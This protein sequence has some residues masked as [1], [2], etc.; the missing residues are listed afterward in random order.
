[1][2]YL[3]FIILHLSFISCLGQNFQIDWK[4][5]YGTVGYD[6][7]KD[8]IQVS[9][10]YLLLNSF[11]QK[12]IWL[13]KTDFSGN[14]IWEKIFGGTSAD[15]AVRILEDEDG[16]Y[17]IFGSSRSS[18]GDVSFDPYPNSLDFWI[19]KIDSL[20]NKIWDKIYGGFDLDEVFN[21]CISPDGGILAVGM[22]NSVDGNVPANYGY[23]DFWVLK[24]DHYGEFEWST[25]VGGGF[26]EQA[27]SVLATSDGGFLVGGQA[28]PELSIGGNL[29]CSS[30]VDK[31]MDMYLIKLDSTGVIEWQQCLGGSEGEYATD[32]IEVDDGYVICGEARSDD[33]DLLNSNYHYGYYHT[34]DPTPDAWVVKTDFIGNL[35][36]QKCYGGSAPE[37]PSRIFKTEKGYRIF[38]TA[39]S[40]DGD[41]TGNNSWNSTYSDI[42]TFEIDSSGSLLSNQCFGSTGF[43]EMLQGVV[44]L[45]DFQFTLSGSTTSQSWSCGDQYDMAFFQITDTLID[46][47]GDYPLY[48]P[49]TIYPNPVVGEVI[50]QNSRRMNVLVSIRDMLGN[51]IKEFVLRDKYLFDTIHLPCGVYLYNYSI[52][53]K[54]FNGKFII[55]KP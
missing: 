53:N 22:T 49:V 17:I 7:G 25:L 32:L 34:G 10:G 38:G 28:S 46:A 55:I 5:C 27:S 54:Q 24:L 15:D 31:F 51:Q 39:Y 37:S 30:D 14:F 40:F 35:T 50:F 11:D 45:S 23:Y 33:G 48:Q 6:L 3:I 19:I 52:G 47:S 44:K 29:T 13:I 21:G 4:K 42:W 8:V 9:D 43:E 41:V 1:M 26:F 2:K 36:W 12:D 16:N 18:N 20:G